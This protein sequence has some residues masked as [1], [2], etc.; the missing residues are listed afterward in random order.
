MRQCL[1]LHVLRERL[2]STE[3]A[4]LGIKAVGDAE[5]GLQVVAEHGHVGQKQSA[6]VDEDAFA[7]RMGQALYFRAA[8][9]GIAE[10]TRDSALH[11]SPF[12]SHKAHVLEDQLDVFALLVKT[13]G[14][15]PRH[16]CRIE[17]ALAQS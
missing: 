3:G 16:R 6:Q 10:G 7:F 13:D 2:Q 17:A 1:D 12:P 15:L 5:C 14:R 8:Q 11:R 4:V 9:D